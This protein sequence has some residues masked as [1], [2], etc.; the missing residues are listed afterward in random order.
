[1]PGFRE[2]AV[3]QQY[4]CHPLVQD[5][6]FFTLPRKLLEAVVGTIGNKR[7]DGDLLGL[8]YALSDACNDTLNVGFW[9]GRPINY[10]LLRPEPLSL[11]SEQLQTLAAALKKTPQRVQD[12]L[13]SAQPSL[14]WNASVSRGY[15]GWLLTSRTFLEEH[16]QLFT[17]WQSEVWKSGVLQLGPLVPKGTT[18][19]GARLV[20][21]KTTLQFAK[22]FEDFYIR[23]RLN[24]L[25]APHLPIPLTP[26][27]SGAFPLTVLE[28]LNGAGGI[29]FIPDTFPI[30]SRD[31]LRQLLDDSL[32][33]DKGP[34]HLSDW[35]RMVRR[36]N[37]AK[38]EIGRLA[39]LFE[40]QHY[41]KVLCQRH[42]QALKRNEG[43]LKQAVAS[44]LKV[45][46]QVVHRDLL[47]IRRR[48]GSEWTQSTI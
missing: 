33:G 2:I 16:R 31:D 35:T 25:A 1:M 42:P 14:A 3:P 29:F 27:L 37:A 24:G 36:S 11:S 22:E 30:P 8:E 5:R 20:S 45:D 23:W 7:F 41:W 6:L 46:E 32:R 47:L 17:K 38:R 34:E 44:F 13:R 4:R 12:M 19:P 26:K 40:L 10:S 48:M 21:S 18:L 15:V 39:R 28:Q 9:G 43:K